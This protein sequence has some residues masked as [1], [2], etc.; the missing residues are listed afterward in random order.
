MNTPLKTAPV[1][2]QIGDVVTLKSG[3]PKMTVTER[4][5]SSNG[6]YSGRINCSWFD[7]ATL[8]Q[9]ISIPQEAFQLCPSL[10]SPQSSAPTA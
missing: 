5:T 8:G 4:L 6:V 9:I 7:G 10:L 3:S 2:F 1:S